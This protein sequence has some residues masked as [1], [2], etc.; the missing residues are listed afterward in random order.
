MLI[1]IAGATASDR[2]GEETQRFAYVFS[3]ASTQLRHRPLGFGA[4]PFSVRIRIGWPPRELGSP[5][6]QMTRWLDANYS[7]EG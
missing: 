3:T 1:S 4:R 2:H 6:Y 5:L 7:A